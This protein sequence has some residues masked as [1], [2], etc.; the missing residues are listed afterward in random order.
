M[1]LLKRT[2]FSKFALYAA[3]DYEGHATR[4]LVTFFAAVWMCR[5][6]ELQSNVR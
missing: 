4:Y 1:I 2:Y 3:V 6:P 5:A